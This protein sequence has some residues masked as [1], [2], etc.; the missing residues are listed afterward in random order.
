MGQERFEIHHDV[1]IV[2][3]QRIIEVYLLSVDREIFGTGVQ[4]VQQ[5]HLTVGTHPVHMNHI[6]VTLKLN[7]VSVICR[8]G[9]H[10]THAQHQE[11]DAT[12]QIMS[13]TSKSHQHINKSITW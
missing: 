4:H 3:T 6:S 1:N 13:I 2:Y 8:M 5:R 7:D 11:E 10:A 9:S 12:S